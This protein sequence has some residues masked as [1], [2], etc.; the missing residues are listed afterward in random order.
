MC[1]FLFSLKIEMDSTL[2]VVP[3]SYQYEYSKF[4][5]HSKIFEYM[6]TGTPVMTYKYEGI[7]E[8]YYDF[9]FL[10]DD[11]GHPVT[12]MYRKMSEILS[13]RLDTI[14]EKGIAA[15][16][17]IL[18]N[19]STSSLSKKIL[20]KLLLR[21][22][23][24]CFITVCHKSDYNYIVIKPKS[25]RYYEETIN[26]TIRVFHKTQFDISVFLPRYIR[27]LFSLHRRFY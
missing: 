12:D 17:F 26:Q 11:T 16:N 22:I 25:A 4:S 3:E 19:N 6:L 24:H 23:R 2:L 14:A 10:V 20:E 27:V 18:S 15:R 1:L 21:D 7:P 9:L 8:A 5:F 13:T